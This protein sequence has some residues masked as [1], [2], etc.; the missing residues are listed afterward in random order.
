MT[1]YVAAT[2]EIATA[3][4]MARDAGR[5]GGAAATRELYAQR[6]RPAIDL[7]ERLCGP[8]L[9]ADAIFNNDDL[10]HPRLTLRPG[11]RLAENCHIKVAQRPESSAA[12]R[13]SG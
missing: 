9:H 1:I 10:A 8:Q 5:L 7:Y 4:G 12:E 3:R 13:L 2:D 11:G 6:Y